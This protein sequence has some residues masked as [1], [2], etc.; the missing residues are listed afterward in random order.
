MKGLLFVYG[1]TYGGAIASLYRPFW[2][3]LIYVAFANLRPDSLWFWSVSPGNYSRIIAIA[4]LLGWQLHGAGS[5]RFGA[6][7][8]TLAV[9]SFFWAWILIGASITPAPEQAWF[10]VEILTK[11]FVPIFA[12]MTLIDSV[13]KLKQLAWVLVA[14]QG[15]LALNFNEQYFRWGINT[16]DWVFAGLDNNGI[17]IATVTAFG[18]ALFVGLHADNWWQRI[19]A[20]AAA[21]LMAHV[22]LFSMSR[23]G[24][25]AMA[26][27]GVVGFI[28]IPK[29]MIH[30][31]ALAAGIVLV[32]GMAGKEVRE[33]FMSSFASKE[34]RDASAE[35]RFGLTRDAL[36]V[37]LRY[38]IL[39][40]GMENWVNIAPEY[41]WPHGKKAHNTWAEI[42][43]TLGLP[44]FLS[45]LGF[46]ILT[47]L[48]LYPLTRERTPVDD[49]WLK[50]AARAVIAATTGFLVSA[51]LVTAERIELPYYIVMLGAGVLRVH[52]L[53]LARVSRPAAVDAH[54]AAVDRLPTWTTVSCR[55]P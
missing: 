29:R 23:G 18:L 44:G 20:F 53:R 19:A 52:S 28:L 16:N 32:V 21:A 43:A 26:I 35:S 40:C 34:Q 5:W 6:A 24:M 37:M 25:L 42:G 41:G 14:T 7:T 13:A 30:F 38:P 9:M 15:F 1:M 22:V 55:T 39:G 4:F 10:T 12:G 48:R 8:P 33:E 47:C 11:V 50:G 46:Y 3:F 31:I 45:I 51:A 2:G 27:T 36:D 49:P 17:A 54:P